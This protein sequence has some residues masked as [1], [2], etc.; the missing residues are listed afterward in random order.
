MFRVNLLRSDM[1]TLKP[2]EPFRFA[3]LP[4]ILFEF[5]PSAIS[6]PI[7]FWFAVLDSRTLSCQPLITTNPCESFDDAVLRRSSLLVVLSRTNPMLF[8]GGGVVENDVLV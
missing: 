6:N 1:K 2:S 7:R 4:R 5:D 3:T 8:R